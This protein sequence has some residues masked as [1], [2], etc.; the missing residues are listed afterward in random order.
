[1]ADR[2]S[3]LTGWSHHLGSIWTTVGCCGRNSSP[4]IAGGWVRHWWSWGEGSNQRRL[5]SWD[6]VGGA[7]KE[8]IYVL[9]LGTP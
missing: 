5:C 9:I 3:N 8:N 7:M 1:M 2:R 4:D 6:D